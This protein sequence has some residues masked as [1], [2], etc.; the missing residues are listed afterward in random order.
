MCIE[1]SKPD[2]QGHTTH[3]GVET[4]CKCRRR[5]GAPR[6]PKREISLTLRHTTCKDR[7]PDR[8]VAHFRDLAAFSYCWIS[9]LTSSWLA[10]WSRNSWKMMWRMWLRRFPAVLAGN[11][12]F[13]RKKGQE[14]EPAHTEIGTIQFSEGREEESTSI[15][16]TWG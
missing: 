15:P 5:S 3:A 6:L 4:A 7:G 11:Q 1:H 2:F 14:V 16:A 10:F 8:D 13:P 9:R 12:R